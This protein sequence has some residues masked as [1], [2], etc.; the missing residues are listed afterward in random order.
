MYVQYNTTKL[1]DTE[2]P[3]GLYRESVR[4]EV[5]QVAQDYRDYDKSKD[6]LEGI[7]RSMSNKELDEN[8]NQLLN[9]Q[10]AERE[11]ILAAENTTVATSASTA[12]LHLAN[13]C[14]DATCPLQ[15]WRN[16]VL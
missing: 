9:T 16:L 12:A 4:D 1:G 2:D 8:I 11:T 14:I 13:P 15:L 10:T 7:Q 5:R 6:K 3:Y